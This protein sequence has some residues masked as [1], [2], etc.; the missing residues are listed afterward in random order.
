MSADARTS[1]C[2][3]PIS[4]AMTSCSASMHSGPRVESRSD[5]ET[6]RPAPIA[7]ADRWLAWVRLNVVTFQVGTSLLMALIVGW[8][9]L[10]L[11]GAQADAELRAEEAEQLRDQ[12][13]RRVDL[14]EA[15]NR[16]ARALASSLELDEAFSAFIRELSAL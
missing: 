12:L 1:I 9:V 8:L 16:A 10:R 5:M 2:S 4:I 6:D 3:S 15:A 14:L 11:R 7:D 13:G